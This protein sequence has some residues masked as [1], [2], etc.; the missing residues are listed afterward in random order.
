MAAPL[1]EEQKQKWKDTIQTQ[2]QSGLSIQKWCRENQVV[3]SRF[4]YWSRKLFSDKAMPHFSRFVEL[5][6]LK[7]CKLSLEY[8]DVH[9]QL[10][11]TNLKQALRLLEKIACS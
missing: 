5:K 4:Y 2:K 1:T 9:L 8:Q 6:D 11:A 7:Q 10:E 3:V